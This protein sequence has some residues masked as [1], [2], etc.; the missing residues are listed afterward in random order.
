MERACH[1]L[2]SP[3]VPISD[4]LISRRQLRA[5][6]PASDMTL[7]RWIEKGQFPPAAETINGFR[8]WRASHVREW[9]AGKRSGWMAADAAA[10]VRRDHTAAARAKRH[11]PEPA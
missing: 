2:N 10:S 8:Y 5:M 4:P 11:A 1:M 9:D 3:A 6:V 7:W